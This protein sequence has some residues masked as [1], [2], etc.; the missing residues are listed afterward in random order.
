MGNC[1]QLQRTPEQ[2]EAFRQAMADP[3]KTLRDAMLAAGYTEWQAKRGIGAVPAALL[4][5][6]G[7]RAQKLAILGKLFS[8]DQRAAMIRGGL[9][10]NIMDRSDKGVRSLEL[11]G[12]DREINMF[13]AEQLTGII[14]VEGAHV[15][16]VDPQ[17]GRRAV[18]RAKALPESGPTLDAPIEVK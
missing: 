9:V 5:I 4:P 15:S 3:S 11:A 2:I 7:E 1:G 16:Q 8:P 13:V 14:V 10:Q 6:V 12:K 17:T 18:M